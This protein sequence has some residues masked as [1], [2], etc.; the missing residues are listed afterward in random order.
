[1]RFNLEPEEIVEEP[2]IPNQRTQHEPDPP[3]TSASSSSSSNSSSSS[4]TSESDRPEQADGNS[5]A[6]STDPNTSRRSSMQIEEPERE[7]SAE[8][9]KNPR[10][11]EKAMALYYQTCHVQVL[12]N[13]KLVRTCR[14]VM[15]FVLILRLGLSGVG[16]TSASADP[17][18][19]STE[20][21]IQVKGSF[22]VSFASIVPP[23]DGSRQTVTGKW[24]HRGSSLGPLR[25][26][27]GRTEFQV[28]RWANDEALSSYAYIVKKRG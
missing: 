25:S 11:E 10:A 21:S 15:I 7:I 16:S 3:G 2:R 5:R 26:W 9:A 27:R 23:T 12:M 24:N 18:A 14:I 6:P 13:V 4:S 1:M 22:W 20:G 28:D 17:L 8:F 19:C